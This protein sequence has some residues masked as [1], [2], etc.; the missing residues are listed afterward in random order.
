MRP[1]PLGLLVL[2]FLPLPGCCSLA[3]L[4]CGPDH[5]KWVSVRFDTPERTVATFFEAIRRDAPDVIGECLAESF[6]KR[7]KLDSFT[8]QVAWQHLLDSNR[9]LHLVGYAEVPPPTLRTASDATFEVDVQGTRIH[10]E[11][12]CESFWEVTYQRDR[13]PAGEKRYPLASWSSLARVE[14]IKDSDPAA[15]RLVMQPLVFGHEG[16]EAVP[17][18]T[19]ERAG[20]IRQWRITDLRVQPTP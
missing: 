10:L 12:A 14:A 1:R 9:G 4:F 7:N 3:R 5:S 11:L 20:L 18:E 17:I 8:V 13:A 6:L 2:A 19:I 16:T 15:S